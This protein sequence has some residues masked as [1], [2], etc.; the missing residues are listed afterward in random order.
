M[1]L[2]SLCSNGASQNSCGGG[3]FLTMFLFVEKYPITL[4]RP[5]HLLCPINH[6]LVHCPLA[7]DG[8]RYRPFTVASRNLAGDAMRGTGGQRMTATPFRRPPGQGKGAEP[9]TLQTWKGR[10]LDFAG[11]LGHGNLRPAM[12][13]HPIMKDEPLTIT[14]IPVKRNCI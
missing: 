9:K 2:C 8:E 3:K 6:L 12:I 14:V 5:P 4:P 11:R 1:I 10:F 7:P 13:M